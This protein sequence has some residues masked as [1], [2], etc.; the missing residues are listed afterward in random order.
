MDRIL[1]EIDLKYL[2]SL[3]MNVKRK[4]FKYS[5]IDETSTEIV[6][7][8]TLS[9]LSFDI[10]KCGLMGDFRRQKYK[11]K[12]QANLRKGTKNYLRIINLNNKAKKI[13]SFV[14]GV[15]DVLFL[16][17]Y[18]DDIRYLFPFS[19][20]GNPYPTY[21]Y[22]TR[23]KEGMV[24][25]EYMVQSNQIIYEKYNKQDEIK[26]LYFRVNYVPNGK[27]K[28]LDYE[29]GVFENNSFINYTLLEYRSWLDELSE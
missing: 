15:V 7:L 17:F 11:I 28:I 14:N 29:K 6:Y 9:S 22:V 3:I 1:K 21:I 27:H 8:R 20:N 18:E 16:A 24:L 19:S 12:I 10:H 5:I 23:Y 2:D 26:T 13:E 4:R 25:E